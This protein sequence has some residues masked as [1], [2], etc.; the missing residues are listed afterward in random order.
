MGVAVC[1]GILDFMGLLPVGE[2]KGET[3]PSAVSSLLP[4]ETTA[5]NTHRLTPARKPP[6]PTPYH[7][8][9]LPLPHTHYNRVKQLYVVDGSL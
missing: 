4:Q 5:Q 3:L 8:H 9:T 2:P 7:E 6:L 1:T